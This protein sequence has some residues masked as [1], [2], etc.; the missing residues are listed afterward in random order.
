MIPRD[1]TAP[2]G[3]EI[4]ITSW[5]V[6]WDSWSQRHPGRIGSHLRI[7]SPSM[8][9]QLQ[10]SGDEIGYLSGRY[11][12]VRCEN[13]N[14]IGSLL[15]GWGSWSQ[16]HPRRRASHA[17][18]RNSSRYLQFQH[19]GDVNGQHTEKYPSARCGNPN[20]TGSPSKRIRRKLLEMAQSSKI[21]N[22]SME[23]RIFALGTSWMVGAIFARSARPIRPRTG[24]KTLII[25]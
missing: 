4:P 22:T 17:R 16:R 6:G 10:Q 21:G 2:H 12:P 5:L 20:T 25:G 19:T 9:L 23:N 3:V 14:P 15:I 18:I 1:D 7:R 13:P 8:H 11:R 24:S